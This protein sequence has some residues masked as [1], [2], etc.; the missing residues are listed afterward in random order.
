MKKFIFYIFV[1]LLLLW[2]QSDVLSQYQSVTINPPDK[3]FFGEQSI[4]INPKNTNQVVAGIMANYLPLTTVMGYCYSTNGG[5][6]W[7]SGPLT[8]SFAQPG[9]DP[10]I[11]V[12]TLGNFY[13][14]CC[15]N[16]GV[17][18]PNLDKLLIFKS[19]NGG[20]NWDGGTAFALMAPQ[21]DDMPMAC[22]DMSNSPYG[23]NIYVTWD[24]YDRYPSTNPL[25][26][27]Y[28]AFCRST[29]GGAT[30]SI[31]VHVSRAPGTARCDNTS[32]EGTSVCTGPNGEVYVSWPLNQT[33]MFNR[34]TNAGDTWLA[35][36]IYVC[37]QV[38][39]WTG[40]GNTWPAWNYSP[41]AACDIS[42]S[43]YRGT[44]YICFADQR[45]G[46]NDRDIWV[47]KST[48]QGNNWTQPKR[49][50]KDGA[51]NNQ[52]LPWICVDRVTGYVWIV[53]YDTRNNAISMS[54]VYV[55]RSTD[56]GETFQE[57]KINNM[58][59]YNGYWFGD[60]IGLDAHNNKV[61]PLWTRPIYNH[62]AEIYTTIIDSFYAIGINSI[63]NEVPEKYSL[64]QNYPNPFNSRTVIRFQVTSG[65]PSDP[66][67]G[68]LQGLGNE[69]VVLKVYDVMG[70][71]LQTLANERMGAGTYEVNFE[72]SGL[73]SGV[74]F[75]KMTAGG[76]SE[77]KRMILM[78]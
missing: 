38:G 52:S 64:N 59:I 12:D 9:S 45:N 13:Y 70:R 20:I 50:N 36:D 6:N 10:I 35:N 46:I 43:P 15:A 66:R 32:P 58:N 41:V 7:S 23:N 49:V 14:I 62:S 51:G 47:V 73:N 61:R 25:D 76:F 75:Y 48:N 1:I 19:T 63:S 31:P 67:S 39:G 18:G 44:I 26:S 60:Y 55:A 21:M 3:N 27:C 74:Y 65:F 54:N 33:V 5:Y 69:K 37:N 16:W 4:K 34:S 78:K 17:T 42:N 71:E 24:L 68:T 77:T 40:I 57:S 72:G 56:G 2:F 30:F 29:D 8:C 22:V 11:V 53:Y 28:V